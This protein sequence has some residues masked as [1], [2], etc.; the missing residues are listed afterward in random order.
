[1]RR[2]AVLTTIISLA[3]PA[4]AGAQSPAPGGTQAPGRPLI[5]AVVCSDGRTSEC[6]RGARLRIVGE[7]LNG[8]ERVHFVG[9]PGR[10]DDRV[11]LPRGATPEALSIVVPR[12]TR[13]GPVEVHGWSGSARVAVDPHHS[14]APRPSPTRIP[15]RRLTFH[16]SSRSSV[17]TS[18]VRRPAAS[19]AV[20]GTRDRTRSLLAARRWSPPCPA[21][22][23]SRR[24]TPAPATTW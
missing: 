2:I 13:S 11:V 15:L 9:G 17:S 8:V 1:M 5:S 7:N 23:S 22:S 12:Q 20:A 6:A 21:A 10:G 14:R 16:R 4:L 18:S 3:T 24:S 19:V